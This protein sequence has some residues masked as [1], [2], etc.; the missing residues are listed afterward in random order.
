MKKVDKKKFLFYFQSKM[1][2]LLTEFSL[3]GAL[4]KHGK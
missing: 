1:K 3:D 4:T 2:M